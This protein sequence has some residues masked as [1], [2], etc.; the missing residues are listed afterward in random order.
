MKVMKLLARLIENNP[1]KIILTI[2][3]KLFSISMTEG[4]I[5]DVIVDVLEALYDKYHPTDSD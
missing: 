3:K 4:A 1:E 2:L 5:I